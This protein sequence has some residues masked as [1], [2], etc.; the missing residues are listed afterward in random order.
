MRGRTV[1]Q[2]AK[3]SWWREEREQGGRVVNVCAKAV[4]LR[5][6]AVPLYFVPCVPRWTVVDVP[7]RNM[8]EGGMSKRGVVGGG[9]EEGG[10][11]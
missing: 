11:R 6:V 8:L 10:D 2:A 7:G 4:R 1:Q 5:P 3:E 9:Q